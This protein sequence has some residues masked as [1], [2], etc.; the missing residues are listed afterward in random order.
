MRSRCASPASRPGAL[1]F[2]IDGD[3]VRR[4]GQASDY[5]VQL[6]LGVFDF[7][8]RAQPGAWVPDPN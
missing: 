8:A 6:M 7:P 5:P 4:L 2:R 3:P 1:E